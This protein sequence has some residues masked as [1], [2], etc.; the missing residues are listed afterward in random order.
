MSGSDDVTDPAVAIGGME[1]KV[2]GSIAGSEVPGSVATSA[3]FAVVGRSAFV[4]GVP[5]SSALREGFVE[6]TSTVVR[7]GD[8][9]NTSSASGP[10]GCASLTF[11][12]MNRRAP[13]EPRGPMSR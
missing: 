12:R 7:L 3:G 5:G 8:A 10:V 9:G 13:G 6:A 11:L 1:G 4:I 2:I